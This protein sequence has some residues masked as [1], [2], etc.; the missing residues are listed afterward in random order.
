MQILVTAVAG[1]L[2]LMTAQFKT[3]DFSAGSDRLIASGYDY[4][5]LEPALG[6]L[7][8]IKYPDDWSDDEIYDFDWTELSKEETR[9]V[10]FDYNA[11]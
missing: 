4:H 5:E 2:V 1:L 7:F 11:L 8:R 9:F 6:S 10:R 3:E